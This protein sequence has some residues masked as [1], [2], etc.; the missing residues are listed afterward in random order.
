MNIVDFQSTEPLSSLYTISFIATLASRAKLSEDTLPVPH[1][2]TIS[3]SVSHYMSHPTFH[4]SKGDGSKA[5]GSGGHLAVR[6][7][8]ERRVE[9]EGPDDEESRL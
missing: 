8:V 7:H 3:N 9:V 5:V 4:C 1:I 6:A 2:S